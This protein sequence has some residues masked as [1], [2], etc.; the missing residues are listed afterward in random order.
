MD[1]GEIKPAR[2]RLNIAP[3]VDIVFLLLIF[4]MLSSH[5][6]DQQGIDVSLPGAGTSTSSDMKTITITI[7]RDNAIF[8]NNTPVPLEKLSTALGAKIKR[9]EKKTV[10]IRADEEI[11]FGLAVAIID[12]AKEVNAEGLII[13][14]KEKDD[15]R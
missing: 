9:S 15:V 2:T 14:T 3:L 1:F 10:T 4:F 5:F 13:S 7:T 8:L 6:V 12:I 11:H